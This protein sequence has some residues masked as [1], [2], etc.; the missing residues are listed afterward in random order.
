MEA[1]DLSADSTVA[2]WSKHIDPLLS[3]AAARD[4]AQEP[5][6]L[7]VVEAQ[8]KVEMGTGGVRL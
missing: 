6:P 4:G 8:G 3:A 5:P 1:P 2:E 7:A